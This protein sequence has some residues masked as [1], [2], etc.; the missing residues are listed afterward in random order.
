MATK[1]VTGVTSRCDHRILDTLEELDIILPQKNG[2]QCD[3][4]RY[5]IH[6]LVRIEI[7]SNS[8]TLNNQLYETCGNCQRPWTK[9]DLCFDC[10]YVDV[11][12][13]VILF[14]HSCSFFSPENL[15]TAKSILQIL[16]DCNGKL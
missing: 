1:G 4:M 13:D 9:Q 5:L 8:S 16:L 6:T 11:Q 15:V 12:Y 14:S 3:I 2:E 10:S 7:D